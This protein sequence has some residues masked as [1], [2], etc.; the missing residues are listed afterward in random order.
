MPILNRDGVKLN[1]ELTNEGHR[2]LVFIHGGFNDKSYFLP[3]HMQFATSHTVLSVDLRGH[4]QS[5]SPEQDFTIEGFASDIAWMCGELGLRSPVFVGHSMGG[6]IAP[7]CAA[8][9]VP[10]TR[11]VVILDTPLLAPR[12]F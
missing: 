11:A 7:E 4:G 2:P 3:Q 6:L 9:Q 1:Y 5:D 12:A 10:D 8:R